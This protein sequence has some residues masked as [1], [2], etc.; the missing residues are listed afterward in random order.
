MSGGVTESSLTQSRWL[1]CSFMPKGQ[2]HTRLEVGIGKQKWLQRTL[3]SMVQ[4]PL[5]TLSSTHTHTHTNTHTHT[6]THRHTDTQTHTHTAC[7]LVWF[8][9]QRALSDPPSY[10]RHQI[11]SVILSLLLLVRTE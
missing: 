4:G 3:G 7:M 10:T 8:E 1:A 11:K 2:P 9:C 6:H 5:I